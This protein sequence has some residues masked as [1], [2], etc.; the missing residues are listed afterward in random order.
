[1][2]RSDLTSRAAPVEMTPEAFREAG[3]RLV[4]EIAAFLESLPRRPVLEAVPGIVV[5][6]GGEVDRNLRP[7]GLRSRRTRRPRPAAPG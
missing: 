2:G 3:H 7:D 4:D 5:R 1:M 6:L